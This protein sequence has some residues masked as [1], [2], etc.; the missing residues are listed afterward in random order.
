MRQWKFSNKIVIAKNK[1]RKNE[2]SEEVTKWYLNFLGK[3]A[4]QDKGNQKIAL[5]T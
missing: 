5:L 4:L 2:N 1:F 3:L